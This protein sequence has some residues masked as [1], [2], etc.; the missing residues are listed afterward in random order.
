MI[1]EIFV[2][3]LFLGKKNQLSLITQTGKN[4]LSDPWETVEGQK[5][6]MVLPSAMSKTISYIT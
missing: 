4:S 6:L 1:P 5:V 2:W 3:A